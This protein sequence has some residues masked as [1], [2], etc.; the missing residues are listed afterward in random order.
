LLNAKTINR[1]AKKACKEKVRLTGYRGL[2]ECD[3]NYSGAE[4]DQRT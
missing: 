2:R 1:V 4:G 3:E